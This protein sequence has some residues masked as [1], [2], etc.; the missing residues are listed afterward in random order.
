MDKAD[1]CVLGKKADVLD[2]NQWKAALTYAGG[3]TED[4]IYNE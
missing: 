1:G 3:E 2:K 4:P